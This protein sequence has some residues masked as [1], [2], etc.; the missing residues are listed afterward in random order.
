MNARTKLHPGAVTQP[1]SDD[2][3]ALLRV[4]IDELRV[5]RSVVN[6]DDTTNALQ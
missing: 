4:L 2:V 5:L 3:P 6:R 1:A